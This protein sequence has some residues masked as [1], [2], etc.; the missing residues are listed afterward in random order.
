MLGS[1]LYHE[2]K[3]DIKNNAP[4]LFK[5]C[6]TKNPKKQTKKE[7]VIV[8]LRGH[9]RDGFKNDKMYR[10]IKK[11]REI[12]HIKLYIHTWTENNGKQSWKNYD[13]RFEHIHNTSIVTDTLIKDYFREIPIE[14]I[15]IENDEQI[16]INGEKTGFICMSNARL[17]LGKICGTEYLQYLIMFLHWILRVPKKQSKLG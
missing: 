10:F 6:N 15:L 7:E 11:I 9:I 17:L 14:Y 12:S 4:M 16:Q 1:I 5:M 13:K 2:K 3:E 8:I